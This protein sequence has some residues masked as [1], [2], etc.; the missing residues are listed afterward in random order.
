MDRKSLQPF[1]KKFPIEIASEIVKQMDH[2]ELC[3]F[4]LT[5]RIYNDEANRVLWRTVHIAFDSD[6]GTLVPAAKA[7]RRDCFRAR[8]IR[9]LVISPKR[10]FDGEKPEGGRW[11]HSLRMQT[12]HVPDDVPLWTW[13]LVAAVIRGVPRLEHL[14]IADAPSSWTGLAK[15][16][17]H[18]LDRL[19]ELSVASPLLDL[20]SF[21]TSIPLQSKMTLFCAR[22]P[23]L[24]RIVL[25]KTYPLDDS[26][27]EELPDIPSNAFQCLRHVTGPIDFVSST[28]PGHPI[29]EIQ[30]NMGLSRAKKLR[31][32]LLSSSACIQS[33]HISSIFSSIHPLAPALLCLAPLPITSL[34]T[35][36]LLS[37]HHLPDT[38]AG[39]NNSHL[40]GS[41][42]VHA[43]TQFS[44]LEAFQCDI[45]MQA[46][47]QQSEIK[48]D[49]VSTAERI[50]F[51]GKA[52]KTLTTLHFTYK[53]GNH[54]EELRFGR[55]IG[56]EWHSDPV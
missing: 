54:I 17:S 18:I 23:R 38:G 55:K 1:P 33:L 8:H 27:N 5:N 20:K 15:W 24:E 30:T 56:G 50:R 12:M 26:P 39:R 48:E 44:S 40:W 34:H 28:T 16:R 2:E 11:R 47:M 7:I 22:C 13:K 52:S 25:H 37:S 3:R 32:A 9:T 42:M 46:R 36:Y 49:L 19:L 29:T 6:T 41:E 14:E 53:Y 31:D 51:W 43:L 35:H 21:T 10:I 4:S 45:I